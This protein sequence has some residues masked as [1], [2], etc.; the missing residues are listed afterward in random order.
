MR[1]RGVNT[2]PAMLTDDVMTVVIVDVTSVSAEA[3]MTETRRTSV[4]QDTA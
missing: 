1:E 2:S 3:R 4:V